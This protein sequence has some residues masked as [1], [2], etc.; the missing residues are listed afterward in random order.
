MALLIIVLLVISYVLKSQFLDRQQES[1]K[2]EALP[3]V[4]E[5]GTIDEPLIQP[6]Q[7]KSTEKQELENK[8]YDEI[9]TNRYSNDLIIET[10]ALIKEINACRSLEYYDKNINVEFDYEFNDTQ[11]LL[12]SGALDG[13]AKFKEDFPTIALMTANKLLNAA[14]DH[15]AKSVNSP[16]A[17]L[18][19]KNMGYDSMNHEQKASYKRE[20]VSFL[21]NSH[22]AQLMLYL[23]ELI[24]SY[25]TSDVLGLSAVV[26]TVN[27]EYHLMVSVKASLLLSCDYNQGITCSPA[28][29]YM[30]NQCVN[31]E[32]AC[33]L[34]LKSWFD[35]INT[36][37]HNRD[38]HDV[39]EHLK[40]L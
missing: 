37:A 26:G 36:P 40:G 39:V 18:F 1:K 38:I 28:S 29:T 11:M 31:N 25:D 33:G 24:Y 14:T 35:H 4:F 19:L 22:N 7:D 3:K 30:I 5:Q 17:E 13:C 27:E 15:L 21:I 6:T 20:L 34:D 23:P 16:H 32:E 12:I 9:S 10:S 2:I 8:W